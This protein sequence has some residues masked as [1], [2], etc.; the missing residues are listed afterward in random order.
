VPKPCVRLDASTCAFRDAI[1]TARVSLR[2]W[3]IMKV[4]SGAHKSKITTAYRDYN[5]HHHI[6]HYPDYVCRFVTSWANKRRDLFQN[7]SKSINVCLISEFLIKESF[8]YCSLITTLITIIILRMTSVISDTSKIG[9][10]W[11][12]PT[13]I[14]R[15]TIYVLQKPIMLLVLLV[16]YTER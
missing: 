5:L 4:P 1:S 11:N 7:L 14:F 16:E 12:S 3:V 10:P 13:S 8:R 15:W 6:C 9:F 2:K